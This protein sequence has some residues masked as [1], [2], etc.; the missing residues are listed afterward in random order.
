MEAFRIIEDRSV[1]GIEDYLRAT[2]LFTH[3]IDLYAANRPQN[4]ETGM[5]FFSFDLGN[6]RRSQMLRNGLLYEDD[7]TNTTIEFIG[8]KRIKHRETIKN[9]RNCTFAIKNNG[10][11]NTPPVSCSN[12]RMTCVKFGIV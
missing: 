3:F 4:A 11:T 1:N 10:N 6:I 7:D 9:D 12:T 5:T 8:V 2:D